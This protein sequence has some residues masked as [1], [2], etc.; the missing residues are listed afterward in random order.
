M[1]AENKRRSGPSQRQNFKEDQYEKQFTTLALAMILA[2]S[3]AIPAGAVSVDSND[4]EDVFDY[5]SAYQWAVEAGFSEGFLKNISEES[6]RHVYYDNKDADYLEIVEEVSVLPPPIG[7]SS[8]RVG[9]IGEDVMEFRSNAVKSVKNGKIEKV[10]VY[11]T[12]QWFNGNPLNRYNDAIVSNWNS[13]TWY[14]DTSAFWGKVE[15]V[16]N[17]SAATADVVYSSTRPAKAEQGGL[18]WYAPLKYSPLGFTPTVRI[19]YVLYPVDSNMS[20]GTR[21]TSSFTAT[22]GHTYSAISGISI[23]VSGVS[24][25]MSGQNTEAAASYSIKHG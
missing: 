23:S 5:N 6:L 15:D 10:N 16:S 13:S 19:G 14:C 1:R 11:F 12:G 2:C 7:S 4:A 8:V 3:L 21:Y 24:V 25:S 9:N 20:D 22:Y 18:G 17:G